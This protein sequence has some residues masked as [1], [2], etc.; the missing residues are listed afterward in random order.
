LKRT[1]LRKK[2]KKDTVLKK[3]QTQV[4]ELWKLVCKQR[5]KVCQMGVY[6]PQYCKCGNQILQVHHIFSRKNTNIFIDIDNGM[7][8][9]RDCH[10]N[11]SFNDD[12][13]E[14]V[15]RIAEKKNKDI[16]DRLLEQSLDR[17]PFLEF[18]N[19]EWLEMQIKILTELAE[20]QING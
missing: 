16:Y 1:R 3:L 14:L 17:K 11:V 15:R 8:L 10:C 18:K 12:Y 13:K 7:L 9:G 20:G 2:S 5:D 19:I 6:Y 4:D